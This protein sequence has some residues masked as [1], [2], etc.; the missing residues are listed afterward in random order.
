MRFPGAGLLPPVEGNSTDGNLKSYL[1]WRQSS[2]VARAISVGRRRGAGSRR[3]ARAS[4]PRAAVAGR[5]RY[6][7]AKRPLHTR[8]AEFGVPGLIERFR[9]TNP[10][11]DAGGKL[12]ALLEKLVEAIGANLG[13]PP[14]LGH[15]RSRWEREALQEL[16]RFAEQA[17]V[18]QPRPVERAPPPPA[19]PTP[20]RPIKPPPPPLVKRSPPSPMK[21]LPQPPR[22]S[23]AAPLHRK[24]ETSPTDASESLPKSRKERLETLI[25]WY[26]DAHAAGA[27]N[28]EKQDAVVKARAER[29]G[30]SLGWKECVDARRAANVAGTPGA[31]SRI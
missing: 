30:A 19:R 14:S 26:Q 22:E 18:E 31:K 9:A 5:V 13:R 11:A 6:A 12:D 27:H 20:P 24:T 4:S 10:P 15:P 28:R 25:R 23:G 3:S 1:I 17:S 7:R 2:F 16:Q 29:A 8:L 21:R